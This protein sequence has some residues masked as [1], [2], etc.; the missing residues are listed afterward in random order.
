M[1]TCA[2]LD[3]NTTVEVLSIGKPALSKYD[4][5][6]EIVGTHLIVN[7]GLMGG[8]IWISAGSM[9]EGGEPQLRFNLGDTPENWVSVRKFLLCL[10]RSGIKS[11]RERPIHIGSTGADGWT[12]G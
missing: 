6:A 7:V 9:D 8:W 3:R 4:C 11:L 10:E 12:I 1:R 2:W 5:V